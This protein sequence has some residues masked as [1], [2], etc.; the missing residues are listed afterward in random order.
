VIFRGDELVNDQWLPREYAK[1]LHD[2]LLDQ[3]YASLDPTS[4]LLGHVLVLQ[5]RLASARQQLQARQPRP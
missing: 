1:D 4:P 2:F 3:R 5:D